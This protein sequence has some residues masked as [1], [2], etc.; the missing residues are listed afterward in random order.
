MSRYL[1]FAQLFLANKIYYKSL[2][3]GYYYHSHPN[4]KFFLSSTELKSY[5]IETTDPNN[6]NLNQIG[7]HAK[8]KC[9]QEWHLYTHLSS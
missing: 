9:D 7:G 5:E 8:I 2:T 3:W 4:S 6:K 1:M